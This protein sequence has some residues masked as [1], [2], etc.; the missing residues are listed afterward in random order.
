MIVESTPAT[1]FTSFDD[2]RVE[3]LEPRLEFTAPADGF[4]VDDCSVYYILGSDG[5]H[6]GPY[7]CIP[8]AS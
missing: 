5:V 8:L 1:P 2:L 3:E 4:C 7:R 6:D